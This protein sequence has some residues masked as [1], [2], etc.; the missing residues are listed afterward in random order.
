MQNKNLKKS[1]HS[2]SSVKQNLLR[3]RIHV[4]GIVQGVGFRPFV[5]NT[6]RRL[7][8]S[9]FVTNS[10]RGVEIE[11]EG[12]P[13]SIKEFKKELLHHP[14]PLSDI[15]NSS[16]E[17]IPA[18]NSTEFLIH[19]SLAGDGNETLISPDV[20][21]C[22]DCLRELFDP[23]DRRYLYPFINCT[24][25]GPRFTIIKD[26]PY[27][28]P[29]TSMS[30]FPLCA[31][32]KAEYEDPENRRFHAQPNACSDCGPQVWFEENQNPEPVSVRDAAFDTA[33]TFLKQGKILAI[34]GL[35]GFHL[36][37]DAL[38]EEAVKRLR[39]R[40][41]REEKPLALMMADLE[42]IRKIAHVSDQEKELLQSPQRP[43]VLLRKKTESPVAHSVA[44]GN[45]RLGI[46]LPYTP[47]HYILF[48][49]LRQ[50]QDKEKLTALVL[51]SANRSEEPIAIDNEEARQRL[52]D[53]TDG[54][55]MH[56]R[57]ILVRGD[58]SVLFTL[59][60]QTQFLRRSRGFVPRPYLLKESGATILAIGAELKN[61]ICMLKGNRAFV[62]QHIGDLENVTANY[63]FNETV[64]TFKQIL[65]CDP[66]NIVYD[67]HPGYF[68]SRWAKEQSGKKLIPVQHHHAHMASCMAEN[69]LDEPVIGLIL[70]GTGYGYDQTIWGGEILTGT[71]TSIERSAWLEPMPLPGGEAAIRQPWRTAAGYLYTT[72]DGKPPELQTLSA[73]PLQVI[74]EMIEKEV[75]TPY[76][77]SCGR[78]FDA[79]AALCGIRGEV[80]Y[81]AQAAIELM[82]LV[83]TLDVKPFEFEIGFPQIPLRPIIRSVTKAILNDQ[84]QSLVAARFHVTLIEL[85]A[86][87][88]KTISKETGIQKIILSGGV[89]QNEVLLAG[90][91][92]RLAELQ[93]ISFTQQRYPMND[94]GISLGQAIIA[95]KL[96]QAGMDKALYSTKKNMTMIQSER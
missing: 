88:L 68:S 47:L 15:I 83:S 52:S 45:Q 35:G 92:N 56:N 87:T 71:Y 72:F 55:L 86:L 20:S 4:N 42:S 1:P 32:C 22:P 18:Q 66:D 3:M 51:T 39:R 30:V 9:G 95:Q 59:N 76:T 67:R 12:I 8:L 91:Q 34:K 5:Y 90:L 73:Y 31:D 50:N 43:I 70:D 14:P 64:Q 7:S 26:I 79:I 2:P 69:D 80:H 74:G 13:S 63:F 78:L 16:F 25:C 57:D 93:L 54:F 53:I 37:V 62:S 96:I 77:S 81:E 82:Q 75:N 89:F 29:F 84:E 85:F 24:N 10:S 61:T 27:D 33:V 94:G 6:A 41:N 46:M 36:A 28:R 11:I 38:N 65:T 44:P 23:Q 19:R 60:E 21:I 17:E 48:D 49:R 58:D 40:K